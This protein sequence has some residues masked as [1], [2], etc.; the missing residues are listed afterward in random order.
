M[1]LSKWKQPFDAVM[2]SKQP[3]RKIKLI[4]Q[5]TK[6]KKLAF[7]VCKQHNAFGNFKANKNYKIFRVWGELAF[8]Y[9]NS[10]SLSLTNKTRNKL[11]WLLG[12]IEV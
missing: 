1:K 9:S 8:V 3:K 4:Q 2:V 7:C 10:A 11:A 12:M 6:N 5:Q